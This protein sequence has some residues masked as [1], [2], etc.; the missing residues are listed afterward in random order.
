[1][2][3][4]SSSKRPFAAP[5]ALVPGAAHAWHRDVPDFEQVYG[6]ARWDWQHSGAPVDALRWSIT[7]RTARRGDQLTR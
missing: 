2:P 7:F 5:P 1:M 6:V 3:A 4:P